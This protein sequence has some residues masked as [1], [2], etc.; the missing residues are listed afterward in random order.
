MHRTPKP[1]RS[2]FTELEYG[3][4]SSIWRRGS[5]TAEQVREDLEPA[6]SLKDST[7]RTLLARLEE[8]GH[9]RH[10][11]EG[12][13]YVYSSVEPPQKFAVRAV[14]QILER[15]CGGSAEQLLAGLVDHEVVDAAQLR[16]LADEIGK[17][18]RGGNRK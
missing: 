18:S 9:L 12:R 13:T 17:R 11:I 5:A 4:M 2:A 8:K 6:H 10:A 1:L 16:R 3:V 14:K 7:V 15:F